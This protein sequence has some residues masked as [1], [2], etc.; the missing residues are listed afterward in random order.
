VVIVPHPTVAI[1]GA[2]P[3]GLMAAERLAAAGCRVTVYERLASPARKLLM[4]GRGGLNLTHSEPL[5][6]FLG[7][8]PGAPAVVLE[9][10]RRFPP[11][12]LVAWTSGLGI[13]TFK[14]SSGR[15]FPQGLKASPLLRAW[16]RRLAALGV[17]L[18]TRHDWTGWDGEGRLTFRLAE[19]PVRAVAADAVLLAAGGASWPRL[20]TD[21][22]WVATLERGDIRVAPLVPA[23]AGVLVPWSA[24]VV[25]RFAGTPLKRIAVQSGHTVHRGEAVVTASGFEGNAIYAA[26]PAIREALR[27]RD[28]TTIAIDF[29]P[30]E[31][32]DAL[33]ERLALPRAK[34]SMA[35]HLRKR[36]ALTPL[37]VALL[38]E[39]S[40]GALPADP[41]ALARLV[42]AAPVTV[43]GVAGLARAI[44]TAGGVA[45]D[46]VDE[47]LMLKARPGTFVAGEM[48]DWE[49]PTGGYL[50]QASFATGVAAAE[51]IARYLGQTTPLSP[52][53][54]S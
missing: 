6:V 53:V 4:A 9:A 24:H 43:T 47:H 39:G 45:L 34:D 8:Y 27:A 50:L 12:A 35:N 28:T 33:A 14:G 7:R 40:K 26:L 48:L 31:S 2:G 38:R 19:G 29:R 21:G 20:G 15:I 17:T 37:Q 16:L 30:D 44:S 46:G 13:E 3:S 23:N 54:T 42:K 18:E 10:V 41:G 25:P 36:L 51:G 22:S 52:T 11:E 49:A 1:V 32:D 5:E